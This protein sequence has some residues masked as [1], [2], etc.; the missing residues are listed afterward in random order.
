MPSKSNKGTTYLYYTALVLVIRFPFSVNLGAKEI[1]SAKVKNMT[2]CF[3]LPGETV[4]STKL[5]RVSHLPFFPLYQNMK[6]FF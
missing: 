3:A 1:E 5:P 6:C 4:N 2:P